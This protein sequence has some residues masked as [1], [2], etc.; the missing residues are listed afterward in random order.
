MLLVVLK[1]RVPAYD[2]RLVDAV[3]APLAQ[4]A[5]RDAGPTSSVSL[6]GV[7]WQYIAPSSESVAGQASTNSRCSRDSRSCTQRAD[8]SSSPASASASVL[9]MMKRARSPSE[10]ASS[11]VSRG[12]A[13]Q[14]RSPPK[15]TTSASTSP[16][17]ASSAGSSRARRRA[18]RPSAP[19]EHLFAD[20]DLVALAHACGLQHRLE[21]RRRRRPSGDPEAA[22][23]VRNTR[24]AR[25][26]GCGR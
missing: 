1:M 25:R 15:T 7:A 22:S 21:V 23:S 24:K 8:S 10:S 4:R 11:S 3:R 13:P 9:P 19:L 16:S 26:D 20:L 5:S 12:H 18:P 2:D 14:I 17:T 6:R